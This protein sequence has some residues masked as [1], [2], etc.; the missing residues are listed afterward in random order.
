MHFKPVGVQQDTTL[1]DLKPINRL[2]PLEASLVCEHM[3]MKSTFPMHSGPDALI[4]C[5]E[6]ES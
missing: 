5:I 2:T 1:V 4:Q 3:A 6:N